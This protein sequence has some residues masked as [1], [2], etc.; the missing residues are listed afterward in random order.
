[1]E[2]NKYSYTDSSH[3][4]HILHRFIKNKIS[5]FGFII[6]ALIILGSAIISVSMPEYNITSANA[7]EIGL[8]AKLFPKGTGWWDGC[9]WKDNYIYDTKNKIPVDLITGEPINRN[10]YLE[11]HL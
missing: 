7:S 2:T 5:V 9:V 8:A 1:M 11:V 6:I 10:A 4:E 3:V